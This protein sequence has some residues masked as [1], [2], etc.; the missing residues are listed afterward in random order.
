MINF[1]LPQGLEDDS[2]VSIRHSLSAL[3]TC[4]TNIME[5]ADFLLTVPILEKLISLVNNPYWLVKVSVV[6][7]LCE[8]V[9]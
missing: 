3:T 6:F 8:I 1:L 5:S 7:Y 9:Y 2:S 4:L